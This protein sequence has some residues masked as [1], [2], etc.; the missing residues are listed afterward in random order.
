[1]EPVARVWDDLV[2]T[3]RSIN[4]T[5]LQ[6]FVDADCTREEMK[7]WRRCNGAKAVNLQMDLNWRW[8]DTVKGVTTETRMGI[9]VDLIAGSAA[10]QIAE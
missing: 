6:V 5:E 7:W 9:E 3:R 4:G 1:M 8:N 2:T 10:T